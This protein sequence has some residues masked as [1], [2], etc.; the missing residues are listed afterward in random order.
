MCSHGREHI[1]DAPKLLPCPFCGEVPVWDG[2]DGDIE[3]VCLNCDLWGIEPKWWNRRVVAS[4][5]VLRELMEAVKDEE[6]AKY[7]YLYQSNFKDLQ[8]AMGRVKAAIARA[9]EALKDE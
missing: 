3:Y 8:R 7:V 1:N 2:Y 6:R 9:E 5:D 4:K